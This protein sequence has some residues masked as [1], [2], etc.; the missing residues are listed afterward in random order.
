MD[1]DTM[2]KALLELLGLLAVAAG[3]IKAIVY[4]ASP[5]RTQRAVLESHS[6]QLAEHTKLIGEQ[7]KAIE[8]LTEM[9][10]DSLKIQISLLNHM[11]DGN[12]YEDMK[13]LRTELQERL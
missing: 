1:A 9:T 8:E 7:Q 4:F 12:G 10:K 11:R 3:G 5:F 13:K 6:R 2:I